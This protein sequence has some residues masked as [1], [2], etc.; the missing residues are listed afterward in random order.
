MD[1]AP[2]RELKIAP[3]AIFDTLADRRTRPRYFLPTP[4]GDWRAVTWGAHAQQIRDVALFLAA[5]GLKGGERACVFAPNRVEWMAAALGIQAAG[6]VMVPVYA[7]STAE[8]AAY[9]VSHSDARVLFVDTAPLVARVLAAWDAY[10]AI[11]RIVILD[12][13]LD[14]G[15]IA[16]ELR[17]RGERVPPFAE[18]ERKVVPWSRACAIGRGRD[19]EDDRAF[20]RTMEGVSLD[21]PG[22]MLYTSGTSGNPKGVPLTHRNVAVNGLDW[23]ESNAPLLTEGDVDLLWLPM[24]H[25]FGFGEACLGNTLGFTTYMGDPRTVLAQL[26]VVRPSVFMSVPLVWEKIATAMAGGTTPE[27]RRAK[28]AEV[29]GGRLRFCLSGGAGLK[30][31]V[32]EL[33]YEHGILIIEGYGLTETSP[34]LTLNRPDAFRFDT[35]GK[36]LPS[37]ELKLAEDGEILARGPSVFGGYHK[38]AEATREAFTADGW[39]KTGDVGRFTDDGFLQVVDRKKDILVTA[40]GKNVPPANIEQRFAD[41][42]FVAHVVVYGDGRKYLVAGVWLNEAVVDAHLAAS[43]VRA[44]GAEA[45]RALVQRRID[46]VNASLASYETIKR[47]AVLT[48]PLTVEGGTLTPTLKV[49]RK[50]VYEA[51]REELEAL[52]A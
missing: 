32:K 25:I 12:D 2:F 44:D 15:K 5:V 50:K 45:V 1:I 34:T 16:A 26:P 17:E 49:R 28:L 52:Y 51:F 7:S 6:G 37:L 14:V 38:D 9:V 8:Q 29:T 30:R 36:P 42:P 48:R 31:E 41:D 11:E 21:Q 4:D 39:F 10:G 35:V 13:A 19:Q 46:Q 43:G 47:F 33:L 40:G 20:E 22:M 18:V 24:S 27:A 23:L 3:R